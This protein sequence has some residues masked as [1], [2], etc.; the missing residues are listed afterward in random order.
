MTNKPLKQNKEQKCKV[1]NRRTKYMFNMNEGLYCDKHEE[2]GLIIQEQRLSIEAF[3]Q[4]MRMFREKSY[5]SFNP[6]HN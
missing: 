1:C 4:R 6:V 2:I 5:L 3:R